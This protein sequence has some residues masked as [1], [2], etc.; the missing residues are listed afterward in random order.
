MGKPTESVPGGNEKQN[1]G[2]G[3]LK[4]FSRPGT[5]STQKGL[6]F[7]ERFFNGREIGRVRRQEHEA[8]ASGFDRLFDTRSLMDA[9][10]IQDHDLSRAHA[11]SKELFHVALK[12][13]SISRSIQEESFSHPLCRPRSDQRHNRSLVARNLA[14]SSLPSGST[15][16]ER[17]HRDMRAGLIDE[18]H[19]LAE[20]LLHLLTPG[21]TSRVILPACSQGLFFRVHPR[22]ALARLM[23]AVLTAMPCAAWNRQQCSSRVASGWA[24]N[25]ALKGACNTAPFL[26]GRPGI[27]FGN[28]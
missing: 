17:R 19:I 11:G 22:A 10:I 8:T 4:S 9:Q 12:S 5:L 2:N 15:G 24:S 27:L 7:G 3:L 28:T 21:R 18:H 14:N 16:I 25:C 13:G 1:L 6:Y 23:L 20:Q 26:A